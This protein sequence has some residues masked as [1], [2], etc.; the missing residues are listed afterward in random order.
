MG[1]IDQASILNELIPEQE[2]TG[3][4]RP[5]FVAVRTMHALYTS[6]DP[7]LGRVIELT[8]IWLW[9]D[10]LDAADVSNFKEQ[11]RL[12][13]KRRAEQ[14]TPP[15]QDFYHQAMGKRDERSLT[16]EEIL[17][18]EFAYLESIWKNFMQRRAEEKS[19]MM[20]I[21]RDPIGGENSVDELIVTLSR[22]IA[23][24]QRLSQEGGLDDRLRDY[25]AKT[26]K[27]EPSQVTAD[28]AAAH[29]DL[30][31]MRLR[32]DLRMGLERGAVLGPPYDYKR[33]QGEEMRRD[34][35]HYRQTLPLVKL[36]SEVLRPVAATA[37]P[38]PAVAVSRPAT[39][40]PAEKPFAEQETLADE[41]PLLL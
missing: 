25:Y 5:G 24:R 18:Y 19:Y 41:G 36:P 34:I 21:K 29:E 7:S 2:E 6:V 20:A 26:L 40:R 38:V 10:I 16:R 32:E 15:M 31:I 14:I 35:E 22:H 9:W 37:T 13:E 12:M 11:K 8:D 4:R 33:S 1:P 17:G 30:A 3:E 39:P 27:C 28:R 23:A